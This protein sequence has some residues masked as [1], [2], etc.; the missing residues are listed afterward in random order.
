MSEP[1]E[2]A[3]DVLGLRLTGLAWGPPDGK[4]LLGLHGWLD[5]AAT[6]SGLAPGLVADGY[7]L[8][9]LDLPGHG[10]SDH[11]P[12]G[13]AYH[14][15]DWVVDVAAAADAL[16][17]QRFSLLAH[18][19][20]AGIASLWAGTQPERVEQLILVEGLGPGAVEAEE[21]PERLQRSIAQRAVPKRVRFFADR[22]EAVARLREVNQSLSEQA[23]RAI[24]ERGTAETPD[25][26][27]W[28]CDPRLR[29]LSPMRTTQAHV[30][31]FLRRITCPTLVV[32]AE[33]G[34]P[35]PP[36]MLA[37]RLACLQDGRLVELPGGHHLHLDDPDPVA[38]VVRAFLREGGN[39]VDAAHQA[40]PAISEAT[41]RLLVL[42]VDGVLTDGSLPFSGEG[43]P[44]KTFNV[45]DGL[46]IKLL[47]QAGLQVAL[48][49]GR[50]S[51]AVETRAAEL[52][53]PHV[54]LG[55]KDKVAALGDLLAQ[56]GLEEGQ[57][58]CMGDDLPDLE[59]LRRVGYPMAP[60]DAVAEV[61]AVAR[62]VTRAPGGRGAVREAAEYLL[63]AQ[64]RWGTVLTHL[65]GAGSA[66]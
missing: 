13:V 23:A 49:S 57:V 43:Q 41:V 62:L 11:R 54:L 15:V 55:V 38:E 12:P 61:K 30:M 53:I 27:T 35:F 42:D 65:R 22:D 18:S 7:R 66:H 26:V 44:T 36:E 8:V 60:A 47:L 32:R 14:F 4:P 45:R 40:G 24:V 29:G 50:A 9:S 59:V 46:G 51:A 64:G 19:M 56:L 58:A 39:S 28:R 2:I 37:D 63:R 34:Y 48:L 5:N 33:R 21:A 20:G 10:L 17:W 16:G 31:A 3:L 25:G 1:E 6:W 52:G